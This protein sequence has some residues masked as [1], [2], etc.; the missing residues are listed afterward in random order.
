MNDGRT[1]VCLEFTPLHD[2]PRYFKRTGAGL[3]SFHDYDD[4]LQHLAIEDSADGPVEEIEFSYQER[5]LAV[6]QLP[7]IPGIPRENRDLENIF[8]LHVP[9]AS[10]ENATEHFWFVA[11]HAGVK[12]KAMYER[13]PYPKVEYP[14]SYRGVSLTEMLEDWKKLY[15]LKR[16]E[17][18]EES[19]LV[20]ISGPSQ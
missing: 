5:A 12:L 10:F 13:R 8:D 11:N 3:L 2:L 14:L 16:F 20:E 18:N 9:Y 15:S 6:F 7:G 17:L 1:V 4:L 19:V